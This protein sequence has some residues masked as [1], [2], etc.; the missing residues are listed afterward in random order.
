MMNINGLILAM[1]QPPAGGGAGGGGSPLQMPVM[2][3]IMVA[4]FYFM[5]IRP[6]QRKDKERRRLLENI[7][8]GDRVAFSGGILGL[9]ANV[10][11]KTLLIKIAENVKVEVSRGAVT[12]VLAKDEDPETEQKK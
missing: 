1:G 2:L 3:L 10:K 12:Q 6:Q 11:D 4:I 7:K 5:L 9:V 8:S